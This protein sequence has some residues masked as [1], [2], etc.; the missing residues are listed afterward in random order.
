MNNSK[1]L[2]QHY[3]GFP[4]SFEL[5]DSYRLVNLTEMSKCFGKKTQDFLRLKSTKD[6]INELERQDGISRLSK[7]KR[8]VKV[9]WGGKN[10]GT[11]GHE[12]IALKFA[13]WLSPAFELWMMEKIREI[14]APARTNDHLNT[15]ELLTLESEDQKEC[16]RLIKK[17]IPVFGTQT[18]LSRNIHVSNATLSCALRGKWEYVKDNI[19]TRM[20]Y[21]LRWIDQHG[22]G[23]DRHTIDLLMEIDD[24][25]VRTQLFNVFKNGLL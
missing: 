15:S 6:F 12:L 13:G 25:K 23:Y 22:I 18:N 20:L 2:T 3:N 16:R 5:G 4:I 21:S 10:P 14:I 11:W 24:K 19:F 1:A 9:V 8:F 7:Q 17:L